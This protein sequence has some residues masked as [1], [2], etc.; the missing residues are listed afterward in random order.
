MTYPFVNLQ[1]IQAYLATLPQ[2]ALIDLLL[3]VAQRDAPL[4]QSLHLKSAALS[5]PVAD[6]DDDQ[7]R[8]DLK[9]VIDD[10]TDIDYL[11]DWQS[12]GV[13]T[14]LLDDMLN[15]LTESLTP[16]RA[17][18]LIGLVRYAIEHVEDMLQNADDPDDDPEGEINEALGKVAHRL[19]HLHLR[20]CQLAQPD[21]LDLAADL[22]LLETTLPMSCGSFGPLTYREVLGD[23]G[24]QRYRELTQA[25]LDALAAKTAPSGLTSQVASLTRMLE[26]VA[27]ARGDI[28]ELVA[29]KSRDLSG[30]RNYQAIA[31]VLQQAGRQ[32]EAL[33][34][35]ERG[36]A[37]FPQHTDNRLRDFLATAYLARGRHEEALQLT[38][39]QFAEQPQLQN[40]QKLHALADKLGLWPAQRLKAHATLHE[41]MARAASATSR[42]NPT[43]P[44]PDATQLLAIALWEGDLDAAL[45]ALD[46]GRCDVYW[47]MQ[48]AQQLEPVR[49]AAAIAIYQQE[50]S[51]TIKLTKNSAYASATEM[52]GKVGRLM[53]VL[54]QRAGFADYLAQLRREHKIKRNFIKLLDGVKS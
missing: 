40:Y 9:Q 46:Q 42:W 48:L 7:W 52:I 10:A 26:D 17:P 25:M 16:A 5:A 54:D 31:E 50:I 30:T 2:A 43:P 47:R 36:A 28:D 21:P 32:D 15:Q 44:G 3:E 14:D 20:A 35:A 49:P 45:A 41:A 22:L 37:A 23:A 24:L 18:E 13:G 38:W 6:D 29:I 11:R 8:S 53:A 39:V 4:R 33:A 12:D 51:A 34:W 19:G 1:P 27:Q